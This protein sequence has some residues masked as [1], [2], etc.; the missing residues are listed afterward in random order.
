[1]QA[2]DVLVVTERGNAQ[3]RGGGTS[4]PPEQLQALILVDGSSTVAQMV[5]R[6][7][8][9]IQGVDAA[10]IARLLEQRYVA[11]AND[12]TADSDSIDPDETLKPKAAAAVAGSVSGFSPLQAHGFHA[13]IALRA[14]AQRKLAPGTKIR[15]LAIDEDANIAKF[16]RAYFEPEEF[17][18]KVAG[19]KTQIVEALRQPPLP[20]VVL[21]DASLP[22]IDAI[23]ATMRRH[24]V[25]GK[26]PVVMF[27]GN[28]TREAAIQALQRGVNAYLTKPLD[29]DLLLA[30]TR[31]VLGLPPQRTPSMG[32]GMASEAPVS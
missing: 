5:E 24:E 19:D 4:L 14:A 12:R 32:F 22:G 6:A 9:V 25:I 17:E 21:A 8:G 16:M 28:D 26:I 11:P 3:L 13:A 2:S 31:S 1:M 30:C 18:L 10:L 20:D 7:Q 27:G 29:M 15:I 23:V